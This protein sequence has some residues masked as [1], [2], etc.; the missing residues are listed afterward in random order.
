[1]DPMTNDINR[2]TIL[3]F[4]MAIVKNTGKEENE[5]NEGTESKRNEN[6]SSVDKEQENQES[7]VSEQAVIIESSPAMPMAYRAIKPYRPK[8]QL[9]HSANS[10]D[11][12]SLYKDTLNYLN[13]FFQP[14]YAVANSAEAFHSVRECAHSY[15]VRKGGFDLA[16]EEELAFQ[17]ELNQG[18]EPCLV[19]G[20]SPVLGQPSLVFLRNRMVFSEYEY[21]LVYLLFCSLDRPHNAL[22]MRDE[23]L[24]LWES[25][26][27]TMEPGQGYLSK[28]LI[29][30][31]I[32]GVQ[33]WSGIAG[34]EKM[35]RAY[36]RLDILMA[37]Q[38]AA[39]G[40]AGQQVGMGKFQ[41]DRSTL[42]WDRIGLA[43]LQGA[44]N[45]SVFKI[46]RIA[47]WLENLKRKDAKQIP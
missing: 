36:V 17:M 19:G 21:G 11:C 20:S 22:R 6:K 40:V 30:I 3:F 13:N 32:K 33:W 8:R 24:D 43:V 34:Q 35:Y 12:A 5:Q 47:K 4:M 16:Q 29:Q 2:T 27:Y 10:Y 38:G 1:M 41:H 7:K 18:L 44:L 31:A 26:K 14:D 25:W 39:T 15:L 28:W 37:I 23:L 46:T 45:G 9:L 42:I